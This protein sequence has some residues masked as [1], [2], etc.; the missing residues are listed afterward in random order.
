MEKKRDKERILITG[1]SK[2]LGY[3]M[4][5][6]FATEGYDVYANYNK[7]CIELNSL[8]QR[9]TSSGYSITAV[10]ADVSKKSEVEM[11][12]DRV[13]SVDILINNAGISQ[14]KQFLDMTEED[15]DNMLTTNLKSAYLCTHEAICSMI[16]NKKGK[17]I[18]ISSIWGVTGGS[19]EVHYSASKAGIIGFTKSLAKEMAPSSIQVNCI[20]PGAID[21]DMNSSLSEKNK[22]ILIEETPMGKLGKPADI[23]KAALFLARDEFITGEVI[24]VNGGLYI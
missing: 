15:W 10:Q 18:N 8:V 17:I 20:A 21:T 1:A 12:F 19:C 5:E 14:F 6:L 3:A 16:S 4:A 9:L 23:A 24:N 2:G 13:G 11:L 22:R 7:H